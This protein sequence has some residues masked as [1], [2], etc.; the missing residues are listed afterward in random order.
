MENP[1]IPLNVDA[2]LLVLAGLTALPVIGVFLLAAPYPQP[3]D[4][5]GFADSRPVAGVPNFWN[6]ASNILFLVF[7][8][9]GMW[10]L[11]QG[12][13][14]ILHSLSPAYRVLFAGIALTALGSGWFHLQP[15]N[16]SLFWDRLPMTLAFMSLF[17]IVLGEHVSET[18]GKRLL[19][20]L[21]IAGAGSVLY[22]DI[23]EAAGRGDLRAYGLVQFLPILLIPA[24]LL[25][26]PSAF[27][28]H[29]F[30]WGAL[31]LYALAKVFEALDAQILSIGGMVSGHS[32]KHMAASFVPFVLIRGMR[33]RKRK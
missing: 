28:R 27:D 5:F 10:L 6:V 26:Y 21:L 17:S 15:S 7:G 3:A 18:L 8:V 4:Y 29:R 20:P 9:A 33:N 1:D 2:R 11:G 14:V 30:L 16:A 19:L 25:M 31:A 32:L 22:W 12:R 13:L 24:I 23:T